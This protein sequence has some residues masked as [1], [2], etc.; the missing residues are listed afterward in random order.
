MLVRLPAFL[1]FHSSS[2]V[3]E[4]FE[5]VVLLRHLDDMKSAYDMREKELKNYTPMLLEKI[6]Q[7][8]YRIKN[9]FIAIND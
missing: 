4:L 5:V 3:E 9:I 1:Y 8:Q 2:P 7:E 6:G